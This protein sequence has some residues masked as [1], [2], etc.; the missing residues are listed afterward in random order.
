MRKAISQLV[1]GREADID[2]VLAQ[3]REW[4][5]EGFELV[6]SASGGIPL[7]AGAADYGR[8]RDAAGKAGVTYTSICASGSGK[9]SLTDP[10]PAKRRL[11]KDELLKAIEAAEALGIDC[12]LVVPGAV[13]KEVAYDVAYDRVIEEM[14]ELAGP[15]EKAGV[16][17]GIEN[18]W[19]KLF[20]S[21]LDMRDAIDRVGSERVGCFF[22]VGNFLFW[23]FPEQW[24]R[25]LGARIK[26]V[27]FK[28]F[29]FE[30]MVCSFTQLAEGQLDWP[31]V[32]KAFGEIGYDDFVISEVPGA[33]EV[34][35]ETSR[36][37]DKILAM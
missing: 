28:D 29:K 6:M 30:N 16:N 27:H 33:D 4:G 5:Y 8:F 17:L 23:S 2:R 34:L 18:V 37:M 31:A 14:K 21:P 13:T 20:V 36:I 12:L 1:Y 24:I 26:K 11:R 10:D 15:A 32:M 35:A 19:N 7:D 3:V 22:D 25:I 9:G